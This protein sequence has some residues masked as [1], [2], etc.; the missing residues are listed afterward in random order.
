MDPVSLSCGLLVDGEQYASDHSVHRAGANVITVISCSSELALELQS[1]YVDGP[2]SSR[3]LVAESLTD[4]L[5]PAEL[6][7]RWLEGIV[8]P[9]GYAPAA[10]LYDHLH[11]LR[12]LIADRRDGT[13]KV[14]GL[15][16]ADLE[17]GRYGSL[18]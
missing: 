13:A 4:G 2:R 11:R 5:Q 1:T 15:E 3:V 10:C 9:I 6:E 8:E 18:H 7:A 14:V 16:V 12:D 17:L